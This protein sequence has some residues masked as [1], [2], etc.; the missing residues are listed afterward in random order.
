M[1]Y[2]ELTKV[3]QIIVTELEKHFIN[4]C[5]RQSDFVHSLVFLLN[6]YKK[7]KGVFKK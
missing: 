5:M 6:K 3:Q 1:K 4:S 7:T 2:E